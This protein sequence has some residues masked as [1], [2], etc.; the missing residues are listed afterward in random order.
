MSLSISYGDLKREISTL[1]SHIASEHLVGKGWIRECVHDYGYMVQT[2]TCGKG[3]CHAVLTAS[4]V[5]MACIKEDRRAI[6]VGAARSV[7][8][9]RMIRAMCISSTNKDLPVEMVGLI[10]SFLAPAEGKAAMGG[11]FGVSMVGGARD[12]SSLWP[13]TMHKEKVGLEASWMIR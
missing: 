13:A 4:A 10:R 3:C 7:L 1:C 9:D 5:R 8:R 2:T 12:L 11:K 6:L